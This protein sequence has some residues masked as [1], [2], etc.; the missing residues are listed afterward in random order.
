MIF[1]NL[2]NF[3]EQYNGEGLYWNYWYHVWKTFSISPFANAV[4]F[5]PGLPAIDS[6]SVSP[7]TATI[8]A[9]QTVLLSATVNT[10]NFASKSVNWTLTGAL[11][12]PT[13]AVDDASATAGETTVGFDGA[14]VEANALAGRKIKFGS[15][16]TVYTIVGNT[17]SALTISPALAANVA[18]NATITAVDS[19]EDISTVATINPLG[20]VYV[21]PSAVSGTTITATATCVVDSTK[22]D[23]AVITVS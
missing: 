4:V 16:T 7:S 9:G 14:E 19:I 3:T 1:D 22:S 20:E 18:D 12:F 6:I 23:S 13:I 17:T 10:E 8:S 15:A 11:P 2:Y 5:V 21:K